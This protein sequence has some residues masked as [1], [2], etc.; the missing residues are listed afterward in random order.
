MVIPITINIHLSI[1]TSKLNGKAGLHYYC[2]IHW[3][4]L[5]NINI[6]MKFNTKKF[7]LEFCHGISIL[8]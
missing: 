6:T 2:L 1:R 7:A 8:H 3:C 5:I 4:V